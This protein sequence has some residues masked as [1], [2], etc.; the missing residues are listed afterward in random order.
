[1]SI[2]IAKEKTRA[3]IDNQTYLRAHPTKRK[4]RFNVQEKRERAESV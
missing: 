1:M 2:K 4:I 3:T